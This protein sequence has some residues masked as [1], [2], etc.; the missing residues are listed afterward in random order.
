MKKQFSII[1]VLILL[2]SISSSFNA[3]GEITKHSDYS[4]SIIENDLKKQDG[5]FIEK[6]EW[7]SPN[8]E[9]PGTYQDYLVKHPNQPA[10]FETI[11][12]LILKLFLL[13]PPGCLPQPQS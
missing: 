4:K 9:L 7:L 13:L 2:I 6:L 10:I 12:P 8:G 11:T 1:V 5:R 3:F